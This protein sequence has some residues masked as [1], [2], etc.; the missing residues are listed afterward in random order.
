MSSTNLVT[1]EAGQTVQ[2]TVIA[3]PLFL[4]YSMCF[5]ECTAAFSNNIH[6]SWLR[7]SQYFVTLDAETGCETDD[8]GCGVSIF[9]GSRRQLV[10][11]FAQL[12]L[13]LPYPTFHCITSL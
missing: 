9:G 7:T 12:S 4:R 2:K 1:G 8:V 11:I 13:I 10:A 6:P 3:L 5:S